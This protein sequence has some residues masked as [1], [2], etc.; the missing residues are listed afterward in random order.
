MLFIV[1]FNFL[2]IYHT[3]TIQPKAYPYKRFVSDVYNEIYIGDENIV[4]FIEVR[5][6]LTGEK[7]T[8]SFR[9]TIDG[10]YMALEEYKSESDL[11]LKYLHHDPD[12]AGLATF[13]VLSD[14]FF[15]VRKLQ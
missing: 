2:G 1:S 7:E 14:R 12:I 11:K 3:V 8:V 6:G 5:P 9:S 4:S 13:K 10:K 15:T